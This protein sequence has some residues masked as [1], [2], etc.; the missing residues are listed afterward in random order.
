MRSASAVRVLRRAEAGL[1]EVFVELR[2]VLLR[3]RRAM[4]RFLFRR[5]AG[6]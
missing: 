2:R 4:F 5:L 6:A 1:R 3:L